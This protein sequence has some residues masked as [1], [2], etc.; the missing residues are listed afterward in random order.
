MRYINYSNLCWH[1]SPP[2]AIQMVLWGVREGVAGEIVQNNAQEGR[3]TALCVEPFCCN[4]IVIS[5][6]PDC[7]TRTVRQICFKKKEIH[8]PTVLQTFFFFF[9]FEQI[10]LSGLFSFRI[11]PKLWLSIRTTQT[12]YKLRHPRP[13]WH[14]NSRPQ[15][16]SGWRQYVPHTA[17]PLRSA[18]GGSPITK[19]ILLYRAQHSCAKT[20]S[21]ELPPR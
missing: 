10:R 6:C 2:Y 18:D 14:L 16:S 17:R 9:F 15:C 7:I 3:R 8:K 19:H 13:E 21:G 1:R 4:Y 11:H 20:S 5:S 12:Y